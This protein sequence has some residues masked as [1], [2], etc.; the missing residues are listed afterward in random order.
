MQLWCWSTVTG[1]EF[2][3]SLYINYIQN[4]VVHILRE[5]LKAWSRLVELTIRIYLERRGTSGRGRPDRRR[6]W[7]CA[8][9]PLSQNPRSKP[10]WRQQIL[11]STR[12]SNSPHS[13][14]QRRTRLVALPGYWAVTVSSRNSPMNRGADN[15]RSTFDNRKR[16]NRS[17][18]I[19]STSLEK[20]VI[21]HEA[22][23][24][25]RLKASGVKVD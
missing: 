9:L 19:T 22:K 13:R 23:T 15:F 17:S 18:G 6:L 7:H 8:R 11:I 1:N 20:S 21:E 16:H 25:I 5:R 3:S 2:S 24:L 10:C 4:Q 14:S 12:R